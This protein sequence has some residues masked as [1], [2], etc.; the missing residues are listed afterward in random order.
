MS[1]SLSP[2]RWPR[3]YISPD[4]PHLVDEQRWD[5]P[6]RPR[7]TLWI[8]TTPPRRAQ[9]VVFRPRR[10]LSTEQRMCLW[11]TLLFLLYMGAQIV[12]AIAGGW[13]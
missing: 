3:L 8:L 2:D 13:L 1:A 4:D 12:R 7:P 10:R 5:A 6:E 9:P 11:I